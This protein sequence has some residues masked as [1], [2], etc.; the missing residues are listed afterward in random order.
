MGWLCRC[1][2]CDMDDYTIGCVTCWE[3][4][5]ARIDRGKSGLLELRTRASMV[6]DYERRRDERARLP[7]PHQLGRKSAGSGNN[8]YRLALGKSEATA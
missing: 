3:R 6:A 8:A 4:C 1:C 7:R 5:T 2:R